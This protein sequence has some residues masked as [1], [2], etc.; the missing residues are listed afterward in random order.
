MDY[1]IKELEEIGQQITQLKLNCK[2]L[3]RQFDTIH[4]LIC[5]GQ[6]GT[7]QERVNQ[8]VKQIEK[9]SLHTKTTEGNKNA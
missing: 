7:W 5:Q 8:V 6:N 4:D 2:W 9:D 1:G 3:I